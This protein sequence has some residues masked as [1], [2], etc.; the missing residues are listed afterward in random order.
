MKTLILLIA[1]LV[2]CNTEEKSTETPQ[3]ENELFY[4]G[5]RQIANF[6]LDNEELV[7]SLLKDSATVGYYWVK[8]GRPPINFLSFSK[9]EAIT[10]SSFISINCGRA[11]TREEMKNI[12]IKQFGIY[13]GFNLQS[14]GQF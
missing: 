12:L 3:S 8:S 5:V 11:Y 9:S 2:G 10:N 1:L 14:R 7:K 4:D 13:Y 6:R